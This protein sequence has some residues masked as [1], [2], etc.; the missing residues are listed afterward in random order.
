MVK[1]RDDPELYE[2]ADKDCQS[3]KRKINYQHTEDDMVD[4][5][6]CGSTY[7]DE[8]DCPGCRR[9][10]A[11]ERLRTPISY[12]SDD[13]KAIDIVNG[14]GH[15]IKSIN[16]SGTKVRIELVN[17][18]GVAFEYV[19]SFDNMSGINMVSIWK[20][21]GASDEDIRSTVLNEPPDW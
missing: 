16:V 17:S 19:Y 5:P 3:R 14:L 11:L 18:E 4:C 2:C 10:E 9:K 13:G 8:D 15:E 20:H 21:L 7:Y 6:K 12:H 1:V